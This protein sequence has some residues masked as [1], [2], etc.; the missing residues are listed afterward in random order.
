[1][2]ISTFAVAVCLLSYGSA[3]E[4]GNFNRLESHLGVLEQKFKNL[5]KQG[6]YYFC[7]T[8]HPIIEHKSWKSSL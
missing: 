6:K 5:E 7:K 3:N 4:R 8:L 2:L 1:M